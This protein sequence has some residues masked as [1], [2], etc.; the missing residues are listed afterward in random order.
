MSNPAGTEIWM[1]K[2]MRWSSLRVLV[3]VV[4]TISSVCLSCGKSSEPTAKGK[5]TFKLDGEPCD[6]S[7]GSNAAYKA[8]LDLTIVRGFGE[9]RELLEIHIPGKSTGTFESPNGGARIKYLN[10]DGRAF[11]IADQSHGY[12]DQF[13]RIKVTGYGEVGEPIE[14]TFSSHMSGGVG[15][16]RE[17]SSMHT[18]L[19][20]SIEEGF[21]S[22]T[23]SADE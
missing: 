5:V 9:G 15:R 17:G 12:K 18:V 16:S 11:S 7:A 6:F 23:R 14:G 1:F 8:N 19:Y 21:F 13:Y 3:V 4:A 10:I 22:V 2:D 20:A